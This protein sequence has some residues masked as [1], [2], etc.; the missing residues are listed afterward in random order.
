MVHVD[1]VKECRAIDN[2]DWSY[3]GL[4]NGADNWGKLF[5]KCK[6]K[7]QSPININT[8]K[9][10]TD[11]SLKKNFRYYNYAIPISKATIYNDGNSGK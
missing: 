8:A 7:R 2:Q 11:T 10:E 5:P 1:A 4:R 3:Y 6:G 9:V